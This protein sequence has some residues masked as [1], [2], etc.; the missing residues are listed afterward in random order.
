MTK[1]VNRIQHLH[2]DVERREV[3]NRD[4]REDRFNENHAPST[5]NV[6]SLPR[7][8]LAGDLVNEGLKVNIFEALD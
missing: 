3:I 5:G 6:S 8:E 7:R 2:G 1:A 4:G